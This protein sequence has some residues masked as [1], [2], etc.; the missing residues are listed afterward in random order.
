V[1]EGKENC[2][3]PTVIPRHVICCIGNWNDLDWIDHILQQ[4]AF[5]SFELDRDFSQLTPDDRMTDSF[6]ASSDRVSPSMS[7]ADRKAI[8]THTAVAYLLSPPVHREHAID[9]S[10]QALL[11]TAALLQSEAVAAKGESAGIAHGRTR[12]LELARQFRHASVTADTIAQGASLYQAWVRRPIE[13]DEDRSFYSCGMHL[14]GEPD[15][16]IEN[17]LDLADALEWMDMLGLYLVGDRPA[18]PPQDNETFGFK[19]YDPGRTIR[20]QPCTRYATDDFMYNPYGCIRLLPN[21]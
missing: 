10:G 9:V 12:W 11:L 21:H 18:R 20:L 19:Q 6:D 15:I 16:E 14:L 17:S 5:A 1:P 8:E 3:M 2:P 13:D 4:P 7:A